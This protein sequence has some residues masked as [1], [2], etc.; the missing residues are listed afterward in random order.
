MVVI[1]NH[2]IKIAAILILI[3]IIYI[4]V[5]V[6]PAVSSYEEKYTISGRDYIKPLDRKHAAL[7]SDVKT[8]KICVYWRGLSFEKDVADIAGKCQAIRR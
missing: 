6:F 2:I 8:R 1:V 7:A 4:A 5:G 3:D